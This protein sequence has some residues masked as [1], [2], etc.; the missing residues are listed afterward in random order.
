MAR[1][2]VV[3]G[4]PLSQGG[5]LTVEQAVDSMAGA[6]R[7][8]EREISSALER[9]ARSNI[10][11]T[12][13]QTARADQRRA[14]LARLSILRADLDGQA[15]LFATDT[16]AR[17]YNGGV[18]RADRM[19][20]AA[21]V[22]PRSSA[23]F[24]MVHRE[25]AEMLA[26][27]AFDDLASATSFM[28][29]QAK[30]TIREAAKL[31]TQV[32]ALAGDRVPDDARRLVRTLSR[33]GVTGF[34]DAAG[35]RWRLSTYAEMV[36]RTKSAHAYNTGTALR[37]EESGTRALEIVDGERSGHAECLQYNRRTCS[38]RWALDHPIEHPNCVRAFGPLPLH[39]GPVDLGAE[40]DDARQAITE[41]HERRRDNG[42]IPD[43]NVLAP[44][45]SR[46][47]LDDVLEDR[48]KWT[49]GVRYLNDGRAMPGPAALA[50]NRALIA[51]GAQAERA[52]D[53]RL[54]ARGIP[55][56]TTADVEVAR[57][58][59]EDAA[60]EWSR[61][62]GRW[63]AEQTRAGAE[64]DDLL[65]LLQAMSEQIDN[66]PATLAWI[67]DDVIAA[68]RAL[69]ATDDAL[70][71]TRRA[72]AAYGEAWQEE[73]RRWLAER[74]G[75]GRAFATTTGAP[76]ALED[77]WQTAQTRYPS[78]WAD[79]WDETVSSVTVTQEVRGWNRTLGNATDGYRVEI[80][81]GPRLSTFV[82]EIGHTFERATPGL[83]EAQ[84]TFLRSRSTG[85]RGGLE[86]AR[87][88]PGYKRSEKH[89]R[90][91]GFM[92]PYSAKVYG[93]G[94]FS[95]YE[96]FTTGVESILGDPVSFR[97]FLADDPEFRRWILGV[98]DNL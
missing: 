11:P 35:H 84:W 45:R 96:I 20:R 17:V 7:Q 54:D 71:A 6:Y 18:S 49:E 51:R 82:H 4:R 9:F 61:A 33:E 26:L 28:D 32:G 16:M 10:D 72:Q 59:Y 75:Q 29:A 78:R 55:R 64:L 14:I 94:P 46:D 66:L 74:H 25:A 30:R 91:T 43:D 23:S 40:G 80:A 95:N 22:D 68:R 37:T 76:D 5:V 13:G 73:A 34:V 86:P 53:N 41:E 62:R 85:P 12:I 24:A 3:P 97:R 92:D 31:R 42:E 15:T 2:P 38:P 81:S 52:I 27:D 47:A 65:P 44:A 89:Y 90:G 19:L 21:G 56:T 98:L 88:I 39:E 36:V 57:R 60:E 77:L 1:Q 8:A 63:L 58:A 50:A 48:D 79:R 70:Q 83:T 87:V 67:S 69:F 93:D